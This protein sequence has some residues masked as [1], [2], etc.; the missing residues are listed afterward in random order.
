MLG[1]RRRTNDHLHPEYWTENDHIRF[2]D[3]VAKEIHDLRSELKVVGQRITA[4]FAGL[5]VLIAVI[6]IAM[7]LWVAFGTPGIN[8]P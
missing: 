5:A 4:L 8:P 6:N 2:E 7:T 3:R 1:P